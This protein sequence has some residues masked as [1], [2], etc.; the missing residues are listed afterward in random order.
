MCPSDGT[1]VICAK[2]QRDEMRNQWNDSTCPIGGPADALLCPLSQLVPLHIY[3]LPCWGDGDL[4][5]W[6]P[7][8]G[9]GR[10]GI[11]AL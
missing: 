7:W 11:R 5:G 9:C 1:E 8:P 2:I 6:L 4:A 3:G 10:V